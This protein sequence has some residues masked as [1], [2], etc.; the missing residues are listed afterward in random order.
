MSQFK[1]PYCSSFIALNVST[2]KS[3]EPYFDGSNMIFSGSDP[4]P[5]ELIQVNFFKCPHCK[6]ISI[7]I[8][9][10]GSKT[11]ELSTWFKPNSTAIQFPEYIPQAIRNDY[12]EA[13][14]IVSLSPKSSA[15]LSRRCL[16]AMIRDFWGIKEST[17]Y[18]EISQLQ[19]K[20]P[21]T[22]WQVID[23]LRQIGNIGAHPEADVNQ[24]IDIEPEDA[25]KLISIIELLLKQWYINRH[26]EQ[27]L[28]KQVLTLNSEKQ[29]KRNHS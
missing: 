20:V 13:C 17:L 23:A 3:Y 22:Q 25:T 10:V 28:Y 29:A 11:K 27:E 21:A 7:H 5:E 8:S 15:T 19:G 2:H 9:G 6:E 1:C 14:A 16:Q 4:I 24:I 18:K 26:E 12:E